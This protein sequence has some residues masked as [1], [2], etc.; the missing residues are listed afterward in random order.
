MLLRNSASEQSYTPGGE[1]AP[2]I[3]DNFIHLLAV[4]Q[5]VVLL[6][7]LLLGLLGRD[8]VGHLAELRVVLVG[9]EDVAGAGDLE[10]GVLD[11][12]LDLEVDVVTLWSPGGGE[13][14]PGVWKDESQ[15]YSSAFSRSTLTFRSRAVLP[16][17]AALLLLLLLLLHSH[18]VGHSS[19]I[20]R[21]HITHTGGRG[22]GRWLPG[23]F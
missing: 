11:Q 17:L 7:L 18:T 5:I 23:Y 9:P 8:L 20:G 13:F 1:P 3:S 15:R 6:L 14:V 22:G 12:E 4:V 16:G 2:D 10:A 21:H 19:C